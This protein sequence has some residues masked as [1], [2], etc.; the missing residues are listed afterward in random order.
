M[1]CHFSPRR[2]FD[3]GF[4]LIEVMIAIVVLAAGLLALTALQG[5]LIRASADSK[6]RSQVAAFAES[7]MDRIRLGGVDQTLSSCPTS[8]PGGL[9]GV[10][11][12]QCTINATQYVWNPA[13]GAFVE[14]AT[15]PDD[16]AYFKRVTLTMGWTDATGGARSLTMTT[17]VS[18]L[19][20]DSSKVMV[21]RAPPDDIGLRPIVRRESPVTEGMI[22]IATGGSGDE[23][24]AATNPKPKLLGGENGSYVA[25]TRY[26]V[27]TFSSDAYTPEGFARFN[28]R[29]ETAIIGCTCQKNA[30]GFSVNGSGSDYM[31][32]AGLKGYRPT[33]W[34]GTTYKDPAIATSPVNSSPA[35]VSQSTLCDVC[36]RDH[37]DPATESGPK[38]SPWPGQDPE[39]YRATSA[40]TFVVAGAD[41]TYQEACRVIRVN[42]VFRVAADPKI[43]DVAMV[44]TRAAPPAASSGSQ[45]GSLSNNTSATSP[46][47]SDQGTA[48]YESYVYTQVNSLY[49]SSSSVAAQGN[50]LSPQ[51]NALNEPQYVPVLPAGDRRW[52]HARVFVT[53][54]LE[55]AARER[56]RK[57]AQECEG[58]GTVQTAQCALPY[59]PLA[60]TN[61]TE[62]AAWMPRAVTAADARPASLV[63]LDPNHLN[64]AKASINRYN[65]GLALV[66]AINANDNA[67]PAL[68]EQL[69][70]QLSNNPP[71]QALWLDAPSPSPSTARYFGN[72]LDPMRGY[73]QTSAPVPF[74]LN[75]N[76]PTGNPSSP[77]SDA[78]KG[79]DP[80]AVVVGGAACSPSMANNTSNPYAC[81]TSSLAD[82]RLL[83]GGYNRIENNTNFNN[84]CGSGKVT[85]PTCV[86]YSFNGASIDTPTGSVVAGS[87]TLES[88]TRGRLDEVIGITIPRVSTSSNSRVTLGFSRTVLE[89]T[90]TCG[91][92]GQPTWTVPCQ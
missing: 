34:D 46:L 44:A 88:G 11:S 4:A 22:P 26:D 45:L 10:S 5:S 49:Y 64:F 92:N 56:L 84:P 76:F 60:T 57:A 15:N 43:Q 24:T 58:V 87:E 81:T 42:G 18:P 37:K 83:L 21:D 63:G 90:Y 73:A 52:L 41:E 16:N 27:L 66:A 29:I 59:V 1:P 50:T 12:L 47:L 14:S 13:T 80:T 78:N 17:D 48:A 70:V 82:V 72:P 8:A 91:T 33:Y 23:Q 28:K 39:H 89:P 75:W 77:V 20:L 9:A 74:E 86:V 36:C 71:V 31:S 7:E 85:K 25:D 61:A 40:T 19:A 79:N 54:Y 65:S 68:D 30:S 67:S 55:T 69:F 3:Q 2:A 53:D 62:I 51:P 35:A 6:A 38:F 32:F